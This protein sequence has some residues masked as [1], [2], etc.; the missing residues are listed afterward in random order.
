MRLYTRST[1]LD[2]E[3]NQASIGKVSD[4]ACDLCRNAP[5]FL[6]VLD[7]FVRD[8]L[9]QRTTFAMLDDDVAQQLRRRSEKYDRLTELRSFRDR[10]DVW[11]SLVSSEELAGGLLLK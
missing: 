3:M 1:D 10:L 11:G 2:V 7:P 5:E 6:V 9:A 4:A 8:A